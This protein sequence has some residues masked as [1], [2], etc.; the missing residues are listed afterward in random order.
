[1]ALNDSFSSRHNMLIAKLHGEI[2]DVC[3]EVGKQWKSQLPMIYEG[4]PLEDIYSC[5]ETGIV[6][7]VASNSF[8]WQGKALAGTSVLKE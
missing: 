8:V 4:Y 3:Q 2:A 1:M 5:D 6:C 7:L